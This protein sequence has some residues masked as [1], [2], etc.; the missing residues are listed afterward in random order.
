MSQPIRAI[1]EG[2]HLRLLDPVELAEGTEVR[3]SITPLPIAA[4]EATARS[5][6]EISE[7]ERMRVALG[8]SVTWPTPRAA[9]DDFDEDAAQR[10]IDEEL[11]AAGYPNA[12]EYIIQERREGP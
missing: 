11:R 6:A 1:Y 10:Q 3:V 2:G 8:D 9:D 7:G 5:W 12:S 4:D